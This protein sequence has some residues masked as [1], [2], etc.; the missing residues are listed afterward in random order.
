M[1][2]NSVLLTS[3]K[4]IQALKFEIMYS[5]G[6]FFITKAYFRFASILDLKDLFSCIK[7]DFVFSQNDINNKPHKYK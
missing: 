4:V 1:K 3:D 7:K 2:S 6:K 5:L